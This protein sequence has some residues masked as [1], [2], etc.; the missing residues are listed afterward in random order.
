MAHKEK[1][2]TQAEVDKI[3]FDERYK[4][5]DS[6]SKANGWFTETDLTEL[7]SAL[8]SQLYRE[9]RRIFS[10]VNSTTIAGRAELIIERFK[11][12]KSRKEFIDL[13][14]KPL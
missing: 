6:H 5:L 8:E 4:V 12:A 9:E 7:I 10:F 14:S 13:L 3:V 1:L 11:V 2:Y